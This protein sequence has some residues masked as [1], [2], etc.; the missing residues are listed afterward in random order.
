MRSL[1]LAKCIF[2]I[3]VT[4]LTVSCSS[5]LNKL[6][7]EP[8]VEL[9]HV[10]V[11]DPTLT[12]AKLIFVLAVE[13]PNPADIKVDELNYRLYFSEKEFSSAKITKTLTVPANSKANVE[14]PVPIE[15]AQVIPGLRQLLTTSKLPYRIAGSAKLSVFNVPFDKKGEIKLR[16]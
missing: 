4:T 10:N 7:K 14:I 16:D 12:G 11:T 2:L 6:V 13:N 5:M 15:Y 1:N 8:K 9:S 3:S